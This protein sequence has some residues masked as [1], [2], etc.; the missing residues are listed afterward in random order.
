M[1]D[2]KRS[3]LVFRNLRYSLGRYSVKKVVLVSIQGR[4][5]SSVS[6]GERRMDRVGDSQRRRWLS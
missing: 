2:R 4:R 3:N 1:I 5:W 6:D